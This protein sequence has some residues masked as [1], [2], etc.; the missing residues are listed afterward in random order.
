VNFTVWRNYFP[1]AIL[2]G[3][4]PDSVTAAERY[5]YRNEADIT[6]V[7]WAIPAAYVSS[8][9]EVLNESGQI[10]R[11]VPPA[12]TDTELERD[13]AAARAQGAEAVA[14]AAQLER[15]TFCCGVTTRFRI[16]RP[17]G[18]VH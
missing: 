9:Y 16:L 1:A 13:A 6:V 8:G 17:R 5:R 14:Q 18:I 12:K 11:V 7:D 4:C 2:L 3:A 10:V 15:H